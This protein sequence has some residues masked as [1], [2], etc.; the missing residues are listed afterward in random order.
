MLFKFVMGFLDSSV[1]KESASNA[2]DLVEFLVGELRSHK[3]HGMAKKG[4]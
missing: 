4:E 3:S 2:G 1:G